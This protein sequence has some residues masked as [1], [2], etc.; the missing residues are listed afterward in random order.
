VLSLQVSVSSFYYLLSIEYLVFASYGAASTCV[1]VVIDTHTVKFRGMGDVLN[2][3]NSWYDYMTQKKE[4]KW[5][6]GKGL[7]DNC[8]I[9][10]L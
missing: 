2:I 5:A 8:T 7:I 6:L 3:R 9:I 10:D 4:G 1:V